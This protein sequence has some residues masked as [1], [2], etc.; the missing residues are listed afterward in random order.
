MFKQS[1]KKFKK[2]NIFFLT[3]APLTW[4]PMG[5]EVRALCFVQSS[6][7]QIILKYLLVYTFFIK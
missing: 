7:K 4:Y 2:G 5:R 6:L 3:L 1:K